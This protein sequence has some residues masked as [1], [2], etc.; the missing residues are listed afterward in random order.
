MHY[1]QLGRL[2]RRTNL[3]ANLQLFFHDFTTS[4]LGFK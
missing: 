1:L 2:L 3:Q 4:N